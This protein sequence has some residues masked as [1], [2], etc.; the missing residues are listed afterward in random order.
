MRTDI[1]NG[2]RLK[3]Q[4]TSADTDWW[5]VVPFWLRQFKPDCLCITD[6]SVHWRWTTQEK[7]T[8]FRFSSQ[9]ETS[10]WCWAHL[11]KIHNKSKC[12]VPKNKKQCRVDILRTSSMCINKSSAR[13]IH[14]LKAQLSLAGEFAPSTD[15][16][17]LSRSSGLDRGWS[18]GHS[19][20]KQT[21]SCEIW[22][23]CRKHSGIYWEANKSRL[24]RC[25]HALITHAARDTVWPHRNTWGQCTW[26]TNISCSTAA[27]R[28]Y[29]QRWK[30]KKKTFTQTKQNPLKGSEPSAAVDL[31][32]PAVT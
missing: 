19:A 21:T 8:N 15:V 11:L 29:V 6:V 14:L 24:S 25:G 1:E 7:L 12:C 5:E 9:P 22:L 16:I 32:W 23:G 18:L 4:R 28:L 10:K 13:F 26:E 27:H 20:F 3:W 2:R 17:P 31:W 30:I